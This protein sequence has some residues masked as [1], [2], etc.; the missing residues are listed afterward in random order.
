MERFR[1]LAIAFDVSA[2][3]ETVT[4]MHETVGKHI[5]SLQLACHPSRTQALLTKL[6]TTQ[7]VPTIRTLELKMVGT[8]ANMDSTMD[9]NALSALPT[10]HAISITG[11]AQQRTKMFAVPSATLA[12]KLL[13]KLRIL[14][15]SGMTKL[16]NK[17]ELI[18]F[19]P[20]V[21]LT[22]L[23]VPCKRD[24]TRSQIFQVLGEQMGSVFE[25]IWAIPQKHTRRDVGI[26]IWRLGQ[27]GTTLMQKF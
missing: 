13:T 22:K 6:G 26:P 11:S 9:L 15:L 24:I 16:S 5:V 7:N 3:L 27:L 14:D 19:K 1:H 4:I 25:R 17:D 8:T 20:L 18:P 23:R 12:D 10:L 2:V 21:N